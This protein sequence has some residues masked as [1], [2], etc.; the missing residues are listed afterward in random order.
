V[1]KYVLRIG[2]VLWILQQIS[3]RPMRYLCR[4]QLLLLLLLSMAVAM[5]AKA[6]SWKACEFND[7]PIP[8]RDR[9]S[10]DGTV[11]ILWSDGK[12]M[13]YRLVNEGFPI[14]T[15]RD[16]L[17]GIWEREVLAQGNAVFTNTTNGNRIVVP[18]R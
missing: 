8:C 16:S 11:R 12:A 6:G 17:G 15:L 4:H 10:P 9:H 5:P 18:L 3:P 7:R 13:T 1:G 2:S 14:S